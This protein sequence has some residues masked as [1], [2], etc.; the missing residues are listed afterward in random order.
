MRKTTANTKLNGEILNAFPLLSGTKQECPLSTLFSNVLEIV[1]S[2]IR[3]EKEIR[4][5]DWEGRSDTVWS[6]THYCLCRKSY[7]IYRQ[8][9]LELIGFQDSVRIED[10]YISIY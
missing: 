6:H 9:K 5:P 8:I 3:Q 10:Q 1:L 4:C 7:G 2:A